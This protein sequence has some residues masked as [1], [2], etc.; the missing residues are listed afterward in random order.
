MV[1]IVNET[2]IVIMVPRMNLVL[3]HGVRV[4]GIKIIMCV[5]IMNLSMATKRRRYYESSGNLSW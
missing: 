3:A 5:I 4:K 1:A 2:N